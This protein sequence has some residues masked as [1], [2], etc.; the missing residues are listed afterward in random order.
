MIQVIKLSSPATHDFWELPVLLEDE[1]ILALDKPAGL[2]SSP[3]RYD[4]NRPNLRKLL[5]AGIELGAP[6]ATQR[7]LSYLMNA[8]R[9]DFE[10]SGVMLLAKSK[11]VLIALAN[12]FGAGQPAKTYVALVQGQPA[13]D[14][15]EVNAK[16]APHPARPGLIRVDSRNGKRSQTHFEVLEKFR[17]HTLL[18]CRPVTGRTHQIRVH[19]KHVGLPV[20]ADE[21]YGGSLLLLSRL[22]CGYRL[23]PNCTERP[24]MGRVALHAT[25]LRIKHPVAGAEVTITSPWPKDLTVAVKYLRRYA[26]V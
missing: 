25:E 9:L 12:A 6:W 22:K 19:L 16:L 11:P 3:D 8:H 23:K 14:K 20:V 1:Y 21:L 26:V 18:Q 10:T 17:N 5:H 13:E 7:G 24:L 4:P 15:F 2:L